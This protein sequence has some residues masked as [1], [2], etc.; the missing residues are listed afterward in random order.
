MDSSSPTP[1]VGD[2]SHRNKLW[3]PEME[4]CLFDVLL[5]EAIDGHTVP[6]GFK[7]TTY[8]TI[9]REVNLKFNESS[10]KDNVLNQVKT[11]KKDYKAIH[12][13]LKKS[14]FRWNNITKRIKIIDE[15]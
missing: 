9:A 15:V 5:K 11:L 4:K 8:S 14:G 6:N 12:G 13:L 1:Q 3:K 2:D 10:S 7:D